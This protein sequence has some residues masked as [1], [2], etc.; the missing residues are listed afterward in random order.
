M[1]KYL[2]LVLQLVNGRAIRKGSL[3]NEEYNRMMNKY[4]ESHPN[5]AIPSYTYF[6]YKFYLINSVEDLESLDKHN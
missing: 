4:K 3:A 5:A 6:L 2:R 1:N